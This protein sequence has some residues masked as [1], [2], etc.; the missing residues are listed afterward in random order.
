MNAAPRDAGVEKVARAIA[1][2]FNNWEGGEYSTEY[3]RD[4]WRARATAAIK[5]IR[6]EIIAEE[7]PKIERAE[8]ER[9]IKLVRTFL[10]PE[11]D[12]GYNGACKDIINALELSLALKDSKP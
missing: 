5:A 11:L 6:D 10:N 2:V 8:R 3:S 9:L 4:Y 12:V 1:E 7:Q